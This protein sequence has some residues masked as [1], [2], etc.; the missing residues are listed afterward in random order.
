MG[1]STQEYWSGVPL[2]SPVLYNRILSFI[3]SIYNSLH[4]LTPNSPSIPPPSPS[5]L[6]T[7]VLF[8]KSVSLPLS[9]RQVHLCLILDSTCKWHHM[10]L[11]SSLWL[12]SLSMIISSCIHVAANGIFSF[13]LWLSIPW[14][15]YLPHLLYPF[16]C[17][18]T[19][20][21][22]PCLCFDHRGACIFS[23]YSFVWVLSLCPGVGL[24][25]DMV[26]MFL[27][28]WGTFIQAYIH[29]NNVGNTFYFFF[30]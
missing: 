2:P 9:H 29:T 3:H 24:L 15:I 6:A 7:T 14:H 23:D 5:P 30:V 17:W 11:C 25:D 12:I 20:R 16:I 26:I 19:F 18:W 8:S 10:Y 13:F 1:F 4:L 22:F 27:V 21:F 28:S